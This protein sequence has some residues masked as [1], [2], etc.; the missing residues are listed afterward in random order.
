VVGYA[1]V[2]Y[3]LI[4]RDDETGELGVAVQ[5]RSF[6]TGAV[7]AWARAG[8]GAIATQSFTDERYGYR[9]LELLADGL[10]PT[11]ALQRLLAEDERAPFRQVAILAAD[12]RTAAHTG[13][14]C[15]AAAGHVALDGMSAQGNMLASGGVW[16]AVADAFRSSTG[17]L[18]HRLLDALDAGERAGGDFRGRQAGGVLV[19]S[20]ERSD[21]APWQGRIVDVRVDDSDEPLHELRRLVRIDD[22]HRRLGRRAPG[23]SVEEEMDAA[24]AAGLRGDEV[25]LAGAAAAAATG[26]VER[27]VALLRTI[28]AADARWLEAFDRYERLGYLPP[29]V[30][31]RLA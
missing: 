26:D 5:S 27:A 1:S 2:T 8:V 9:G 31:S 22:A 6:N 4:A 15:V 13:E 24:R 14:L 21:D 12:G 30:T 11:D 3:S 18:A 20:A 28:V 19:V 25:T 16:P 7:C 10:S 17:P 29:G 23:A